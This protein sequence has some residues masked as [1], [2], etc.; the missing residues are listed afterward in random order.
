[1]MKKNLLF[2]AAF[3]IST[4][5]FCME[6]ENNSNINRQYTY[7]DGVGVG[8][9]VVNYPQDESSF[10]EPVLPNRF[11]KIADFEISSIP[12][13][14]ESIINPTIIADENENHDFGFKLNS[15]AFD[16]KMPV[17][18]FSIFNVIDKT[19]NFFQAN[20]KYMLGSAIIIGVTYL[21][22]KKLNEKK[23]YLKLFRE[24]LVADTR[25]EIKYVIEQF[26]AILQKNDLQEL[27]DFYEDP[28]IWV[29]L[30]YEQSYLLKEFIKIKQMQN[31]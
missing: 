31:I 20:Y 9:G 17:L 7:E 8:L 19:A 3:L 29:I 25:F 16:L 18:G 1:M 23:D 21:I 30:N 27:I 22:Y 15:D 2:I 4:N 11:V 10:N 13:S 14:E 12:L 5:L 26:D 24:S 28:A 6:S